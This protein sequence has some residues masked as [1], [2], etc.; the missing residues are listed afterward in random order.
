MAF[1]ARVIV[2]TARHAM[3]GLS[4]IQ[5]AVAKSLRSAHWLSCMSLFMY[6][7]E[8]IEMENKIIRNKASSLVISCTYVPFDKSSIQH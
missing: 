5:E 3:I 8:N 4:N 7:I 2:R 6:N 1:G